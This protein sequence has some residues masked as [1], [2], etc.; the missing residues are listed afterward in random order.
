MDFAEEDNRAR[1]THIDNRYNLEDRKILKTSHSRIFILFY[2]CKAMQAPGH[3]F[4]ERSKRKKNKLPESVI[5][6]NPKEMKHN[7]KEKFKLFI[8]AKVS[9]GKDEGKGRGKMEK[10]KKNK[11]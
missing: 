8:L 9:K 4:R 3:N 5:T 11:N 1:I 6:L 7:L 10:R 2:C